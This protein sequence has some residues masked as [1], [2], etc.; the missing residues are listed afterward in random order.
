MN[1]LQMPYDELLATVKKDI[2]LELRYIARVI[3]VNNL[4]NY[5]KLVKDLSYL[6]DEVVCLS[7][8]K[9]CKGPDTKPDMGIV[10]EYL[11][12][13][14]DKNVLLLSV[15]EY[16]RFSKEKEAEEMHLRSI[17]RFAAH[18]SKRLWI[19]LYSCKNIFEE[20]VQDLEEERYELWSLDEEAD[21][22]E[23]FVYSDKFA[24]NTG[25][26]DIKGFRDF[27]K[28]WDTLNIES[29]ISFSTKWL[30]SFQ[31]SDG[32]YTV[33]IIES[34]FS[35]IEESLT[36]H[37]VK[38]SESLGTPAQWASLA[39]FVKGS[40]G[41]LE[42]LLLKALNIGTF[43]AQQVVSEWQALAKNN[44][45]GK[46]VLWLWYKLGLTAPGDYLGYSICRAKS[47]SGIFDEIERAILQATTSPKFDDWLIERQQ[48]IKNIGVT[49]LSPQYWELFEEIDDDRT[50]L[51]LL[52]N[53]TQEERCRIIEILSKALKNGRSIS[54][55]KAILNEKYPD[56]L[57]YLAEPQF[58]DGSLAE[59]IQSYKQFKI[60]DYYD[61][62]ISEAAEDVDVFDYE[63]RSVILNKIKNSSDAYYLWIDGM[64]VEWVDLLIKKV[65]AK[66]PKLSNPKVEIGMASIPTI[67]S[68][69]MNKADPDTVS[70]KY[71]NLDFLS[72]IKGPC[73][74]NYY[75]IIDQQFDVIG[76][77][78][79]LVVS[80]YHNNP[81]KKIVVT[82]D[83]G[84]SRMAAK[85]FHEKQAI[86]PPPE[87]IS[88]EN[89]GRYCILKAGANVYSFAHT[90]KEDNYLAFR[91]HSHFVASGNALGEIHGGATPEEWLVPII[92]F[93]ASP[94]VLTANEKTTYKL[95]TTTAAPDIAGNI[96]LRIRVSGKV[97]SVLFEVGTV[98]Y[99]GTKENDSEWTVTIGNQVPGSTISVRVNLN[100]VFNK[101]TESVDIKRRGLEVDDD[102]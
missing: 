43:N 99:A 95:L 31:P 53:N 29:G 60:M 69:N 68:A 8:E 55:F 74:C 61:L 100:N 33:R 88:V 90:F 39:K 77:V 12:G 32:N 97:E 34:P 7:D 40:D 17:M 93:D 1:V 27:F 64:G 73:D 2:G 14:T 71:N 6:A 63:T 10:K 37:N 11:A 67:T 83:H 4:D 42:T 52:S 92:V 51:K 23:A 84:M 80:A 85:A 94:I 76:Q 15:G 36:S 21:E 45:F 82:A 89:H 16:L 81:G 75:S 98:S 30:K 58:I 87:A 20:V 9:F 102:F 41:S 72:H 57:T 96:E 13:R 62:S 91:E 79:D 28:Q 70:F 38:F 18:S 48:A 24:E 3:F 5:I 19:P 66:L 50:K 59:Y 44:D 26:V 101:A 56:M 54:D 78:A 22:F 86:T 65:S 49:N 35:Y 47:P 25:V 46:W